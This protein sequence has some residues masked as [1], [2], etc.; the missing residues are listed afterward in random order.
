MDTRVSEGNAG[1]DRQKRNRHRAVFDHEGHF[2]DAARV[3]GPAQPAARDGREAD[4]GARTDREPG[5]RGRL[6]D[7]QAA[8]RRRRR[9]RRHQARG[10]EHDGDVRVPH[11]GAEGREEQDRDRQ[12][13]VRED[14]AAPAADAAA[15]P[16]P[17][18]GQ[19]KDC[20]GARAGREPF[21]GFRAGRRRGG[22]RCRLLQPAGG[23]NHGPDDPIPGA[24]T[25][26]R[27]T[28]RRLRQDDAFAAVL[29]TERRVQIDLGEHGDA[30]PE[31]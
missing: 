10:R 12:G 11:R 17:R 22:G 31:L 29:G 28:M 25:L 1:E 2:E 21:P 8:R 6:R 4:A 14:A 26:L 30:M 13:V 24:E 7:L 16:H 20:G 5:A 27:N 19:R 15:H 18:H 23:G 9:R 3:S